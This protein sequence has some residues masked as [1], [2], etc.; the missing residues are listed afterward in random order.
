MAAT[1]SVWGQG[2]ENLGQDEAS[3][4]RIGEAIDALRGQVL[5]TLRALD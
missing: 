5:I 4:G 2:W 1:A 3:A